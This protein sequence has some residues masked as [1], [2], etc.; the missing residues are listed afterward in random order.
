[1]DLLEQARDLGDE[2]AAEVLDQLRED[3]G[4]TVPEDE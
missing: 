2:R 4:L 1:M 3:T